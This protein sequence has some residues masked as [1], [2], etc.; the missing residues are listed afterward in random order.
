[1]NKSLKANITHTH[2][3][4][5]VEKNEGQGQKTQYNLLSFPSSKRSHDLSTKF[6]PF[7]FQRKKAFIS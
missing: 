6:A 2:K 4:K 3:K 7:N 5:S 1:M